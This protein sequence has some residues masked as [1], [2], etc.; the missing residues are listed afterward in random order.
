MLI[1]IDNAESVL[2]LQEEGNQKIYTL[3]EELSQFRNICLFITSWISTIPPGCEILDIPTLSIEAAQKTFYHIYKHSGQ[4]DLAN[5]ILEQLDPHPLSVAL[6]ATVSQHNRWSPSWLAKEWEKQRTEMLHVQHNKSLAAT[7]ELSLAS[8]MLQELGPDAH[9]LLGVV[10]FFPQGIDENNLDWLFPTISNRTNIFYK[11][12]ILS[13][14]HQSNGFITMLAPLRDYLCPKDPMSAPLLCI[15]KDCYFS[16]LSVEVDPNLPGF[17]A[18]QWITSED[19]NVEHLPNVF[20]TIDAASGDVWEACIHFMEHLCCYKPQLVMLGP[21]VEGLPDSHP[22]KPKCLT[23]PSELFHSVGNYVEQKRLLI[24]TLELQK[25]QGN[26]PEVAKILGYLSQT[27]RSLKLYAEG[28]QQAKEVL[29]IYRQLNHKVKQAQCLKTLAYLLHAEKELDAAGEAALQSIN[30][31][32][33]TDDQYTVSKSYRVL[34]NI[35]HSKGDREKAAKH[36]ETA[37]GIASPFKWNDQLFWNHYALAELFCGGGRF[38]DAHTH[39]EHEKSHSTNRMYRLGCVM[40]LQANIL[41]QQV[42]LEESKSEALSAFG[43]F[44]ELGASKKA[45]ACR[46]FLKRIEKKMNGEFQILYYFTCLF[47]YLFL[48]QGAEGSGN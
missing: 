28:I 20:T 25:R 23:R 47:T 40:S 42:R 37:L 45:E 15:A 6:L 31:L 29:E 4:S 2:H 5:H 7:I 22:S 17:Q 46:R 41:F 27:S 11:F 48:A 18:A 30:L 8:P 1:V 24:Y 10:A 16:K 14:T 35:Y 36:Y 34:G 26:K 13:L 21:K 32:S 39:I 33:D 12:C 9:A 3:V 44:E 43:V 38:N 19:V